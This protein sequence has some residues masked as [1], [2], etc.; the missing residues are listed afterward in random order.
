MEDGFRMTKTS[1]SQATAAHNLL[2]AIRRRILEREGPFIG[3]AAAAAAAGYTENAKD[4]G[5]AMGQ[6]TSRID[7]ASFYA[8]LPMLAVHWVR[9]PDGKINPA[10]FPGSWAPYKDEIESVASTHTWRVEEVDQVL[11]KMHSTLDPNEGAVTLWKYVESRRL[12]TPGFVEH[13]LHR[14][15]RT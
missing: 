9:N 7:L 14:A 6:V 11:A 5:R 2:Q 3:Y 4:A 10:S 8:G 1:M 15:L 12:D 13:Y